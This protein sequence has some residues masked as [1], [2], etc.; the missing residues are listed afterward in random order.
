MPIFPFFL[1]TWAIDF[2][3]KTCE[4]KY[5]YIF[6]EKFARQGIFLLFITHLD[7]LSNPFS[8]LIHASHPHTRLYHFQIVIQE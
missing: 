3:L 2:S 7:I 8:L 4:D 6:Y 5:F 1:F